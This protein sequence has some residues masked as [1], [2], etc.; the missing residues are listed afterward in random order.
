MRRLILLAAVAALFLVALPVASA[1]A[2]PPEQV[3]FEGDAFFGG[4]NAGF[5]DFKASGPAFDSGAMCEF[6][7]TEDLATRT[8][9]TR[10]GVHLRILKEFTC[11]DDSGTFLV[12]LKVRIPFGQLST[13]KWV[14]V[15]GTD[16][17]ANLKGNGSGYA[18]SWLIAEPPDLPDQI[19]VVD[20]YEGK[21]H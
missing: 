5:G 8:H 2:A 7:T 10:K 18:D 12:K 19:G 15:G 16:A 14:V 3:T 6:G 11:T 1:V 17:Y 13:F 9:Q 21:L 4:P 20:F